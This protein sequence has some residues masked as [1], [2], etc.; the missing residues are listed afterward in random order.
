[1]VASLVG[2][3]W[4]AER[5]RRLRGSILELV[6]LVEAQRAQI[7]VLRALVVELDEK[8]K[9]AKDKLEKDTEKRQRS[10]RESVYDDI[11]DTDLRYTGTATGA[12]MYPRAGVSRLFGERFNQDQE[13]WSN[14]PAKRRRPKPLNFAPVPMPL[15]PRSPYPMWKEG[16]SPDLHVSRDPLSQWSEQ[17]NEGLQNRRRGVTTESNTN[18][19]HSGR[20]LATPGANALSPSRGG[21]NGL[22][23]FSLGGDFYDSPSSHAIDDFGGLA[24]TG[25]DNSGLGGFSFYGDLYGSPSSGAIGGFG[26]PAHTG[27]GSSD[28]MPQKA[29]AARAPIVEIGSRPFPP[30]ASWTG[31]LAK[32]PVNV[33][34]GE[35]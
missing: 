16:L 28:A 5:L 30:G 24:H 22:G 27:D 35:L 31:N 19:G 8:H 26:G 29:K 2:A 11:Y 32:A 6:A 1:M 7:E 4:V 25:G 15:P 20:G 12:E 34:D 13:A 23:G 18:P 10:Y 14:K 17:I 21:N 9:S 3:N 33:V